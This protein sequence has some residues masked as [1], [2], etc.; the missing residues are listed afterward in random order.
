MKPPGSNADRFTGRV[1]DYEK[2]RLGYPAEVLAVLREHGA[3]RTGDLVAD[4]GAGTG[5]V[6][7]LFLEAGHRVIAVEPNAEMRAACHRLLGAYAGLTVVDATAETT[8]LAAGSVDLVSVGRAFHWFDQARALEEFRRVLKPGGWVVVLSNRRK[9]TGSAQA[10]EYEALLLEHGLDY[11]K[12][13]PGYRSYAG[14]RPYGESARFDVT[15]AGVEELTLE[16]FL[17]QTQ[18]YSMVPLPGD[19]K[20]AGMQ[21]ALRAFFARWSVNGLLPVATECWVV[22]WQTG[23]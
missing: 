20:F 19:P 4:V 6:A 11:G 21:A 1:A 7:Q 3:L 8:G 15:M 16:A 5:M 14:L 22:G 13:K 10:E 17:G 9:Q 12:V 18:S 23:D 2:Y